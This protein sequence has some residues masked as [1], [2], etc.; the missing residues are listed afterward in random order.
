MAGE[1]KRRQRMR[2]RKEEV[3]VE[4]FKDREGGWRVQLQSS[5]KPDGTNTSLRQ[6]SCA[7]RGGNNL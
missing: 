6:E 7:C 2:M 4:V 3:L 5:T 1:R